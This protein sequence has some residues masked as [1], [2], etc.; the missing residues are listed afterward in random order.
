MSAYQ[1]ARYRSL[2]RQETAPG[3]RDQQPEVIAG[4]WA[5]PDGPAPT[6]PPA[7]PARSRRRYVPYALLDAH[8]AT[9][10]DRQSRTYLVL[11]PRCHRLIT[12]RG[13][14][15]IYVEMVWGERRCCQGC[16]A[17]AAFSALSQS[18]WAPRIDH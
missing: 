9:W 7:A 4:D 8:L 2:E 3:S 14:D 16:R 5:F 6:P 1:E 12:F 13:L 15:A 18:P 17:V 10:Y 11:C